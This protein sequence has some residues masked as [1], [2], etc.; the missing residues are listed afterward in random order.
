MFILYAGL[1]FICFIL[2]I[3]NFIDTKNFLSSYFIISAITTTTRLF[4]NS[5]SLILKTSHLYYSIIIISSIIG[6]LTTSKKFKYSILIITIILIMCSYFFNIDIRTNN[7][8]FISEISTF[9]F[10]GIYKELYKKIYCY[11][12]FILLTGTFLNNIWLLIIR[13]NAK[14]LNELVHIDL[15]NNFSCAFLITFYLIFIIYHVKYRINK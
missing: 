7:F 10:I 12:F 11:L 5:P 1:L 2:I 9:I 3:T 14:I 6:I 15:Y 8:V 4:S 13:Q